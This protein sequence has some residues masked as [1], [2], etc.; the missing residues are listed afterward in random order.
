MRCLR[1]AYSG[2][3]YASHSSDKATRADSVLRPRACS[4]RLH[5]VVAKRLE[6]DGFDEFS[7]EDPIPRF[8]ETVPGQAADRTDPAVI[9]IP[10]RG[11]LKKV[12]NVRTEKLQLILEPVNPGANCY[13]EEEISVPASAAD[14]ADNDAVKESYEHIGTGKMP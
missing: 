2:S 8:P 10:V 4:T 9:R 7:S 1:K 12:C 13:S 6:E 3:Q 14:K 5:R 11:I